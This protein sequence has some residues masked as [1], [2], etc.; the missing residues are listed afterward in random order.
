MLRCARCGYRL[1]AFESDCPVCA[2]GER[3][4]SSWACSVCAARNPV[5]TRT[6]R[7]CGA[8]RQKRAAVAAEKLVQF[9]PRLIAQIIDAVV[10]LLATAGLVLGGMLL[11]PQW[12]LEGQR[13][14]GLTVDQFAL[15]AAIAIGLI[16]HTALVSVWGATVGKLVLGMRVVRVNG[17]PV[18]WWDA[19]LRTIGLLASL[20]T[21]GIVFLWIAR[22]RKNQGLHDK[23]AG[24]LVVRV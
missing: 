5:D 21:L 1:S 19:L 2:R 22:D 9:V 10:V 23:L 6:C 8:A 3:A 13:L 4:V 15:V 14:L 7:Q 24:T 16:Y 18:V 20:V 12:G 11:N 17:A